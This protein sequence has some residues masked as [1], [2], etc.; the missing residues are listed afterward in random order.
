[1]IG[2]ALENGEFHLLGTYDRFFAGEGLGEQA[3]YHVTK[4]LG[5]ITDVVWK[6]SSYTGWAFGF[7]Y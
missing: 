3:T 4:G 7:N 5:K 2:V 6:P 1:M